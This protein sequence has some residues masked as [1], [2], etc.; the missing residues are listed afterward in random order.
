MPTRFPRDLDLITIYM[1]Q[2]ANNEISN[3]LQTEAPAIS[4]CIL[5][6]QLLLEQGAIEA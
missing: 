2:D 5:M 3:A 6:Q 1:A 4:F